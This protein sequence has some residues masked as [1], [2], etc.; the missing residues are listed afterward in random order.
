MYNSI[1]SDVH[2]PI[3]AY[4]I[5]TFHHFSYHTILFF[6]ISTYFFYQ[7]YGHHRY[8]H[9]FPTRRSSDL[10]IHSLKKASQNKNPLFHQNQYYQQGFLTD[11]QN[12][13]SEEHTSELQ[14]QST[15][16]YAVFCLKKKKQKKI[17]KI[18]KMIIHQ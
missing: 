3:H 12:R 16:S 10:Q 2:L 14:S 11:K 13:R 18:K 1:S 9:S 6:H 17:T 4:H 15:N 7:S 8:L 5:D